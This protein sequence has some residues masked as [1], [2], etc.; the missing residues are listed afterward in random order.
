MRILVIQHDV[1]KGLGLFEQPLADAA[2]DLDFRFAGQEEIEPADHAAVIALPGIANPDEDSIAIT[3]TRAALREALRRDLPVLGICLGAELLA[4][5]AGAASRPC[6]PE[7]GYRQ[8]ELTPA[9]AGDALLGALPAAFDVFQA[10]N[11]GCDLPPVSVA[12][13]AADG[14]LQAFRTGACAW[15][16][17]FHPEPT[18]AMID[19]W[20][21]ALGHL[22]QAHGVD[23][24]LT[25]TLA[26]QRVPEWDARVAE[27]ARRFA[28]VVQERPPAKAAG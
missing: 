18:I 8:V 19:G 21:G 27:M 4:E 7:W 15:G 26:R 24:E 9:A 13:A 12:L 2:L 3:A 20:T 10:H 16:V 17:Q 23:P 1:D 22:M 14:A 28:A 6:A 11:F 25:R 5:A